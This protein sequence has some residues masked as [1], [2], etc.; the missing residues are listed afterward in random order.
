MLT[1]LAAP[2]E[3]LPEGLELRGD[4]ALD[5]EH[6][7]QGPGRQAEA[8]VVVHLGQQLLDV[9][10]RMPDDRAVGQLE[11]L[12]IPQ[13]AQREPGAE[14]LDPG[15]EVVEGE[16]VPRCAG[17]LPRIGRGL[18]TILALITALAQPR[19]TA[20]RGL[21]PLQPDPGRESRGGGGG[22]R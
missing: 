11:W 6:L 10:V 15:G 13:F 17:S 2:V 7:G 21:R 3:P 18:R 9:S 4:L 22:G 8:A 1:T 14:R 20:A 19:L 12:D 5:L 16:V